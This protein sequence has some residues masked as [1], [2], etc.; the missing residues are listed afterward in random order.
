MKATYSDEN[1]ENYVKGDGAT[2]KTLQKLE[3][4]AHFKEFYSGKYSEYDNN[5]T[6]DVENGTLNIKVVNKVG[7]KLPAT[8]STMTV[9]L[10]GAGTAMMATAL[11][12]RK[13]KM[14]N[15]H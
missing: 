12:K 14:N 7:S 5:L 11:I 13:K 4:T 3:A 10:V 2:D 1:R 15:E 8:G 9:I 6:T